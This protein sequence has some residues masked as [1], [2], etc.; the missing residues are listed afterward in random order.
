[1][2]EYQVA[3]PYFSDKDISWIQENVGHVLRG[4]LS[5]GPY[6]KEFE[7][8]FAKRIGCKYALFVNNCTTALEISVKNFDLKED[9]EVIVPVQTFI[10]SGMAVTSNGGKVVFAEVNPKTFNLS[11][12]EVKVRTT[13]KTKG[14]ILVHF[15]GNV[16]PDTLMIRKYCNENDL[17]LIEDCAHAPGAS[18]EG[19]SV[20]TI[21]HTGC[22][23]FFS[24]KVITTGEGGMLTTN[25]E[26]IY[27]YSKAL[28]ERGRSLTNPVEIY[29]Y[30]WRSGRVPEVSAL[31]GLSQL[32]HLDEWL[33]HRNQIAK[34]YNSILAESLDVHTI[35]TPKNVFNAYWKH[36][37]IIDNNDIDRE[38]LSKSLKD[39]FG[40]NINWAY[41]PPL[42][43]QPVYRKMY[44]TNKGDFPISEDIMS[45]HFHLPMQVTISLKDANFIAESVLTVLDRLKA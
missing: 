4:R 5:T 11:L 28:R 12:E 38:V 30:G 43:L 14:V 20:G 24:T 1:M 45:K 10:A 17:F 31:L 34:I 40:I 9:D 18:I 25:S 16:S 8:K 44:D 26:E 27:N 29:D 6:T 21:G 15:A 41:M 3:L 33:D 13:D 2:K 32:S 7:E 37:T 39:D 23:S 42:H 22:F 36:I 19:Q 35:N